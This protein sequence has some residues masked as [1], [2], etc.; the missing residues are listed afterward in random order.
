MHTTPLNLICGSGL[1]GVW[2]KVCCACHCQHLLF[3]FSSDKV[4]NID[5][6]NSWQCYSRPINGQCTN[7][8]LFDVALQL[9]LLSKGL[10]QLLV[11]LWIL[12]R[13][14][15]AAL[16]YLHI[17]Y[18]FCIGIRCTYLTNL[19]D[20]MQLLMH[21]TKN[22]KSITVKSICERFISDW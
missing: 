10:K 21:V 7:F 20:N 9:P 22:V 12:T 1:Q 13:M 14:S 8:I 17:R 19:S 6:I 2:D 5:I 3:S 16:V 4:F 11:H 15:R 18:V